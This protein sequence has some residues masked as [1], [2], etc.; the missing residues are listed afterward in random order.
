MLQRLTL[1]AALFW[2]TVLEAQN[3]ELLGEFKIGFVG[4]DQENVIGTFAVAAA[5]L[6]HDRHCEDILL[7][8]LR[9]LSDLTDY[10]LIASGTSQRQI[11]SVATELSDFA[12]MRRGV[13][14]LGL[15]G[16]DAANWV[17]LDFIDVVVHLFEAETRV[18]YD[19]EMM[20]GDAASVV[21]ER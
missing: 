8:D 4:R 11:K 16:N 1:L 7:F 21:W 2:C 20:W 3:R 14:R 13:E 17:V 5:R 6:C 12:D 10:I 9:G 19:L 15:E 18:H